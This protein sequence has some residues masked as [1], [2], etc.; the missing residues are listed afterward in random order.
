MPS[1]AGRVSLQKARST[2]RRW[3]SWQYSAMPVKSGLY[4]A[5][6]NHDGQPRESRARRATVLSVSI[7]YLAFA[8]PTSMLG[9]LWPDVRERF[10]QSL[11]KLGLVTLAYGIGRLSTATIGRRAIHRM[12]MG[13]AFTAGLVTFAI[14]CALMA[15]STSWLMFLASAAAIGAAAGALDSVGATFIAGRASVGDAGLI[16]GSYGIGATIGP[17][18]V[19]SVQNWRVSAAAGAVVAGGAL[20]AA[21]S[22]KSEWPSLAKAGPS[23]PQPTG[24]PPRFA[25]TVSMLALGAFVAV[26]VTTGLWAFTYL[27]EGRG[28]SERAAAIGVAG[29]WGGATL[30]RITMAH[31]SIAR[32][33]T[34]IGL[35]GLASACAAMLVGLVVAPRSAGLGCLVLA[36]V[37]LAPIV[38]SMFATTSVRVGTSF[39][40]RVSGWQL[41]ATNLG[42]IS[43]P[44]LVGQLVDSR[45]P[46]I[47]PTVAIAVVVAVGLPLLLVTKRLPNL[48]PAPTVGRT[49]GE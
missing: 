24:R 42:A 32:L 14:T 26:E 22:A 10:G 38:P 4:S 45:G 41:I 7:T 46:D 36:G 47:I 33:I 9:V 1:T 44:A 19:A 16:H 15:L 30:G 27:T 2:R 8:V 35:P 28:I 34:R 25:V 39:V 40:T 49:L 3:R 29:F 20:V 6:V 18:I 23:E 17:V 31:P 13:S 12:G 48:S 11:G 43:V 21:A 5:R 37:A